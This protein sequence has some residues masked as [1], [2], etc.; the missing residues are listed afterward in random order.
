MHDSTV[1]ATSDVAATVG[2]YG[3]TSQRRHVD[4]VPYMQW[5]CRTMDVTSATCYSVIRN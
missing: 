4:N 2:S 1:A 5:H 3:V